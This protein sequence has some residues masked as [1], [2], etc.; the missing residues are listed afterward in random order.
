VLAVVLDLIPIGV[1]A[2]FRARRVITLFDPRVEHALT[3]AGKEAPV[4][5]KPQAHRSLALLFFWLCCFHKSAIVTMICVKVREE[6]EER[7]TNGA[8]GHLDTRPASRARPL[9]CFLS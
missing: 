3:D 1:L 7:T 9:P 2:L 4:L 6:R 8:S 5:A